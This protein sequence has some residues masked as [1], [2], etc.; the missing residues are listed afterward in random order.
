MAEDFKKLKIWQNAHELML[1]VYE[2]TNTFPKE[3]T[4]N[5]TSQIRRAAT[6]VSA[7]IAEA[8]GRYHDAETIHFIYNARGSAEEVRSHLTACI[9]L[10]YISKKDFDKLEEEYIGLIKGMNSFIRS[11]KHKALN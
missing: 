4:F 9:D 2:L 5:L 7:N 10:D 11:I 1:R 8:Q 3:E 6:S